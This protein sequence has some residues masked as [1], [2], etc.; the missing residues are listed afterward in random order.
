MWKRR[1]GLAVFIAISALGA[2]AVVFKYRSS[3]F[4][5]DPTITDTAWIS[6]AD[7]VCGDRIA[8]LQEQRDEESKADDDEAAN[9]AR[10][11]RAADGLTKV[12]ADLRELRPNAANR[13]EVDAWLDQWDKFI[14]A[15]RD[16][17]AALRR[18][19]PDEYREVAKRG[20]DPAEAI[21]TFA[22]RNRIANCN[23]VV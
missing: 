16:Y 13:A 14:E 2:G 10:I 3:I 20:Q 4:P 18:G 12:V 1:R 9:A 17:A 23:A 21:R 6:A 5:A 15:G 11:G 19:D 22:F 8:K 7:R